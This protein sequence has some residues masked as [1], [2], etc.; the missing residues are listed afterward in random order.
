MEIPDEIRKKARAFE[1]A[2]HN[3]DDYNTQW[4]DKYGHLTCDGRRPDADEHKLLDLLFAARAHWEAISVA[5]GLDLAAFLI[6]A[7][8][9]P[10]YRPDYGDHMVCECG[11]NYRNHFDAEADMDPV[12]CRHCSCRNFVWSG[13]K[14]ES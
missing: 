2:W 14:E 11:H 13:E 1:K 4:H 3:Y 12:G 8:Y 7:S 6:R 10:T 9:R 5:V